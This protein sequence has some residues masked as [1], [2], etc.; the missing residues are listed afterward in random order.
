MNILMIVFY[1]INTCI[2]SACS[3]QYLLSEVFAIFYKD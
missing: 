1:N 3:V 2:H